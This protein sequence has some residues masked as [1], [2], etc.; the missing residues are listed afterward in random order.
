TNQVS[1]HDPALGTD[2]TKEAINT[3]DAAV[4]TSQLAALPAES[5]AAGFT[6]SWLGQDEVAGSGL[7]GYDVLVS[8]NGGN[9]I[10]R[11]QGTSDTSGTFVGVP[12][13]L[14]SFYSVARDN[15]GHVE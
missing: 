7:A 1:P 14:Y 10:P 12:G 8:D 6:V 11:K 3:I 4:P 9:Y 2:S 13:H 15:V 5:N